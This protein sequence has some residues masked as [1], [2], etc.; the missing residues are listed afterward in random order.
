MKPIPSS[1]TR[2]ITLDIHKHYALVAAVDR[3]G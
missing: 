2:Y 3:E 1:S